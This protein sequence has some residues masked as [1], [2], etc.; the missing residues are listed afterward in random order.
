MWDAPRIGC[1]E[2]EEEFKKAVDDDLDI[3]KAVALMRKM[4]KSDDPTH[5]KH[6][7]LLKMDEVLGLGIA[8]VKKA[9]LPRGAR[10]LI[11]E[12]EELRK[13]GK[14]KEADEIRGRLINMG[15][16]IED[17][18]EGSTWKV[19]HSINSVQEK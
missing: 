9:S 4:V 7:T 18:K 5:A 14:F 8:K 6:Q 17:T 10:E 1:S 15:V 13:S 3:P 11:T 2:F 12:R 16:T 19:I